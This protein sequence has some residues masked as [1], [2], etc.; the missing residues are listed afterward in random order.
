MNAINEEPEPHEIEALLPWYA[1]GTLSRRDAN[2][3][4]QALA[5]EIGDDD[6]RH[7][8]TAAHPANYGARKLDK[9]MA[10]TAALHQVSCKNEGGDG[11]QH[12]TLRAG[13]QRRRQLLQR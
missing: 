1:A 8:E 10:H 6:H 11:Q 5:G 2:R 7:P 4:E 13:D 9:R 12:P 3:V